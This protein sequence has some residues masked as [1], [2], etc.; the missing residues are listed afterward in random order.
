MMLESLAFK[1]FA[2]YYLALGLVV[3][4]V[5]VRWSLK[6]TTMSS[7]LLAKTSQEAPPEKI[8]TAVTYLF[9]FTL[10]SLVLSFFP[11]SWIELLFSIWSLI[12]V[13]LVGIQ[14][15]RWQQV[16]QLITDHFDQLPVTIRRVGAIMVAVALVIFLL[17]YLHINRIDIL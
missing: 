13:Y 17:D 15:V 11:F 9:F 8:R 3:L 1:W 16:S 12:V 6:P 5:G 7:Y 2:V 10:P 4:A 14:L